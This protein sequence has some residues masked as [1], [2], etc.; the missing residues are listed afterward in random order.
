LEI[1]D[2]EDEE[3]EGRKILFKILERLAEKGYFQNTQQFHRCQFSL[4]NN[5]SFV[6]IIRSMKKL[7][8]LTTDAHY[9]TLEDLALVFQSCSKL[10]VLD[11]Y[12]HQF[13]MDEAVI[14]QLK[15]GFQ[16]LR[17]LNLECAIVSW[18][19]IQEMLT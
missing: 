15:P 10:V 5:S 3:E 8:I 7:E 19:G 13:E 9:L 16:R 14:D 6:K 11:I 2:L 17:R 18:A 12:I 1:D 4:Y